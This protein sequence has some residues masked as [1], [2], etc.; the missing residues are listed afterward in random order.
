MTQHTHHNRG[1][2]TLALAALTALGGLTLAPT[3]GAQSNVE[4]LQREIE[5]SKQRIAALEQQLASLKLNAGAAQP[6]S[7]GDVTQRLDAL[8]EQLFDLEERVGDRA[9]VHAFDGLALDIGGFITQTYTVALGEDSN[10]SSP[11]Q[12]LFELLIKAQVT[13]DWSIFL[14]QGFLREADLDFS[15]RRNPTFRSSANRV[16][17]II[18]WT[19]YK[20]SDAL[21]LQFGRFVTPHGII[22]IEHFP[23]VLLDIN[24]PQFLRPFSGATIFPNFLLGGQAHG[25]LF[26]GADDQDILQYNAYVGMFA[27]EP[28]DVLAGA[29]VAYTFS[30]LG[31]TIGANYA[32]G[33][34]Q[35]GDSSLGNL[36]I[37]GALSKTTN[38]YNTVGVDV[39]IDKGALLWKNE[40]FYSFEENGAEDRIAFYTQPAWRINDK[41]IAFYRFDFLDPGQGIGEGIEHMV[42]VNFLPISTIRLRAVYIF[43]Q[44]NNPDEDA[45]IFQLSATISF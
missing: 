33:R 40:L 39:L 43:K 5:A 6:A 19:N 25:K 4:Q 24:Q 12:T 3:A 16:P 45:N 32:H 14:A 15:D 17:Q 23:P 28:E 18:A 31:L 22:N 27:A 1:A 7:G 20:I 37:V 41:W 44:F 35:K 21:E 36:S 42:G 9:V 8:E 34:R 29:R 11:N 10:E 38:D 2:A 30:D 26:M 13:E